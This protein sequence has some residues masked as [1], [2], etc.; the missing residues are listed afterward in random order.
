[1]RILIIFAIVFMA[2]SKQKEVKPL[3]KIR[4]ISINCYCKS[5]QFKLHYRRNYNIVD[6]IINSTS[7][8]TTTTMYIEQTQLY[9]WFYMESILKIEKDSMNFKVNDFQKNIVFSNVTSKIVCQ[10]NI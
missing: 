1:M 7:Y 3:P 10:P 5:G 4:Q 2:C 6:T 9:L 8:H